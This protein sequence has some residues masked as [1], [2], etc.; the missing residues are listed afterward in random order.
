MASSRI[1][2]SAFLSRVWGASG[3]VVLI[4]AYVASLVWVA[5]LS[6]EQVEDVRSDTTVL[7]LAHSIAD[8]RIQAAFEEMADEYE[9]LH[10]GV[11]V[12]IQAIPRRAYQQW[13]TTQ[14][15][16]KTVPDIV[17]A[18]SKWD[19]WSSLAARYMVPLSTQVNHTNP[20]N[21]GGELEGV[22]WRLTYVDG[23]QGG[24]WQHLTEYFS[25]PITTETVRIYYNKD[26]F[27]EATGSDAAPEDL[28]SWFEVCDRL[29]ALGEAQSRKLSPIA[30]SRDVMY[31]VVMDRYYRAIC[32][33]MGDRFDACYWGSNRQ[34]QT[35]FG[36]YTGTWSF[37]DPR[38]RDAF[39]VVK[40]IA[41]YCQPGF[42][43]SDDSQARFLFLQGKAAMIMGSARDAAIYMAM[44]DFEIGVF[45]FPMPS[46]DHPTLGKYGARPPAETGGDAIHFCVS[47]QSTHTDEALDLLMFMSSQK[48]N[49]RFNK[50]V[51]WY[52]A[53]RGAEP[54]PELRA[55]KPN[56]GGVSGR[57]Q[58]LTVAP[59][60]DLW[61]QQQLP[62]YLDGQMS[63]KELSAGLDR[64]WLEK[65]PDDFVRRDQIYAGILTQAEYNIAN[66][67]S[68]ML[69]A[70]AGE[71][72]SGE[73][74]G[75]R[76]AYQL[77]IEVNELLRFGISGRAY[78]W[79]HLQKDNYEFP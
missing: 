37:D 11:R 7:R 64:I 52:P 74:I 21:D 71:I 12:D 2:K 20:Y 54:R 14:C 27:T 15:L 53:I 9:A 44:A 46:P 73:L 69:F 58:A 32:N 4:G 31:R 41:G 6:V 18:E 25:V 45:D 68:K 49:E 51:A 39:E 60:V 62:R 3:F 57:V 65:G 13:V 36:R 38:V 70:E 72:K 29:N 22:P 59:G 24:Y 43:G 79:H 66:A 35:L 42:A 5:S 55:F 16:G 50:A 40:Q 63:F 76:T 33:G 30:G 56:I 17:Q 75:K 67:K 61:F 26:L 47:R 8:R 10:P 19:L 23:M 77:A 78:T 34:E 28:T 1:D 48:V